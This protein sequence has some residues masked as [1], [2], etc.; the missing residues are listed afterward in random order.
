MNISSTTQ[1]FAQGKVL[2]NMYSQKN[3]YYKHANLFCD[4]K[5]AIHSMLPIKY[6]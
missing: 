1:G 2:K 3:K 5:W 4:D 6:F